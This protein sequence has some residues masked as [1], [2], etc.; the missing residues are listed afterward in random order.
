MKFMGWAIVAV[1]GLQMPAA[2]AASEISVAPVLGMTSFSLRGSGITGS[3][4]GA[5][6]GAQVGF[7]SGVDGLSY[8]TGLHY[9]Q[10][11]AKNDA[12]FA[13][14]EYELGYLT[15]PAGVKYAF[16]ESKTWY[17]RAGTTFAFLLSAKTK[18]MFFG[19]E[20]RYR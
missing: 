15:I 12:I 9:T 5:V 8:E 4:A 14:T 19:I 7:A 16:T 10:A 20:R 3:R 11:G 2:Q 6:A 1:L 13:S 18:D 17:A